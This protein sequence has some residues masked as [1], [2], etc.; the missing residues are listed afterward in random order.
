[1]QIKRQIE[2]TCSCLNYKWLLS[3]KRRYLV[4]FI[5]KRL[6]MKRREKEGGKEEKG[7]RRLGDSDDRGV[8][9]LAN[10]TLALL[11]SRL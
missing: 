6:F 5:F 1:M 9:Y 11:W 10:K 4:K 3:N 7:K 2:T 8:N